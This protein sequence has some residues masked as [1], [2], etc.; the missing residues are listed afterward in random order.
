ML[1]LGALAACGGSEGEPE[2]ESE[3]PIAEPAPPAGAMEG[4]EGMGGV[5]DAEQAGLPPELQGHMQMMDGASGDELANMVPE[6]RQLVANM[7]AR[8]NREMRDMDMAGNTEWNET[9]QSLR[10]DLV[11]LPE[12]TGDE[13]RTFLPEHQARLERLAGMHRSMMGSMQM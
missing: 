11:R 13:I 4:M 7:I 6:H 8:M 1:V 12:M 5:A 9:V 2:A 10:D 3:V